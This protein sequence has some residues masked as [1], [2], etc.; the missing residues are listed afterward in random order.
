MRATLPR[1]AAPAASRIPTWAAPLA[2]FLAACLLYAIN[3]GRPLTHDELYH[4]LAA[5]GWLATGEPRIGEGLYARSLVTTWLVAQSF[6][7][8]GESA[9]AARLVA[10]P[11]VAATVAL[12]FVWL[13]RSAG[14]TAAWFGAGLFAIS[15]FAV[16]IAQFVRFYALQGLA[17]LA[18]TLLIATAAAPG[19]RH[20]R[21]ACLLAGA[22]CLAAAAMLNENALLG[23]VGVGLW[24]AGALLLPWL[25]DPTVPPGP[26]RGLLALLGLTILAGFATLMA[27]GLLAEA[28][29]QYRAFPQFNTVNADRFWFYHFWYMLFYPTLWPLTGLLALVAL[30]AWPRPASLALV[31]FATTFLL[32][33]FAGSKTL[34]Y[35]AYAQPFL[36]ALWGMG[37]AALLPWLGR[38]LARL[39]RRLAALLRPVRA[40]FLAR[41][42]LMGAVLFLLLAN[43]AWLR[44]ATLIANV[45]VPPELPPEDWAAARP[46]LAVPLAEARLVVSTS[47]LA[48]LYYLGRADVSLSRSKLF[49]LAVT[50]PPEF[51]RDGRTGV[52]VIS[53][54]AS[55]ARLLDC[56]PS[57]LIVGSLNDWRQDARITPA[58]RELL[59]ARATPIAL[60]PRTHLFAYRWDEPAAGTGGCGDLPAE[61]PAGHIG[62]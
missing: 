35:V 22:A 26:R 43:P 36:F 15:P 32:G 56:Y 42:L 20:R 38:V 13:R 17:F 30:A 2:L 37:L 61:L 1:V 41:G 7:L 5:R 60:P 18:G 54:A 27:T 10:L 4:V 59:A 33:S 21:V 52:P 47:E 11:V 3:L 8:L 19:A 53:T 57:G 25:A 16:E 44:T 49:E 23:L 6:A 14:S 24:T 48:A 29:Q 55:L 31:V 40:A 58:I 62:Q 45:P 46:A 39:V 9:A 50:P 34:R 12:L 28:W 51:T